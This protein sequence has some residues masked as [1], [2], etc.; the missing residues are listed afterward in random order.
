MED[1]KRRCC[2]PGSCPC[3]P[4]C[5]QMMSD[6]WK[7]EKSSGQRFAYLDK[8]ESELMKLARQDEEDLAAM[9]ELYPARIRQILE[10]VENTCDSMEY[11]GSVMFD[12]LPEK[13]RIQELSESIRSKMAA[14]MEKWEEETAKLQEEDIYVMNH[15]PGRRPDMPPGPPPYPG[16]MPPPGPPAPP[17]PVDWFADLVHVL[18]QDEMYH[19]RCRHRNCR[20]W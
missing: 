14:Q 8:E 12:E 18:L 3:Y 2:G 17:R 6:D 13:Q 7:P 10:E 19:R 16:M 1:R 11:E 5:D 15:A 4:N 20:R 9:K